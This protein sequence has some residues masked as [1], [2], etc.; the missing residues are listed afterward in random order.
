MSGSSKACDVVEQIAKP[1]FKA[2]MTVRLAVAGAF[3]TDFME[4]AVDKVWVVGLLLLSSY[5]QLLGSLLHSSLPSAQYVR[6][7][8][9]QSYGCCLR[10]ALPDAWYVRVAVSS[11]LCCRAVHSIMACSRHTGSMY[12]SL[13]VVRCRAVDSVVATQPLIAFSHSPLYS[14]G[15]TNRRNCA[16]AR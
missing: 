2:R 14:I 4:A 16:S 12:E 6:I 8:C 9:V 13:K 3:H 5:D 1:D 11:R 10:I 7:A 15:G